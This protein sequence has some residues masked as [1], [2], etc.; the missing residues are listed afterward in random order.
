MLAPGDWGKKE[1]RISSYS[2]VMEVDGRV[3]LSGQGG[4]DPG[5]LEFPTGRSIEAE[6]NQAFENVSFMLNAVGLDWRNVAHVN[7]Y[8][9]AGA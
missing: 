4:W 9:C 8:H 6:I 5:T 7:S 1:R 2:M 3:E